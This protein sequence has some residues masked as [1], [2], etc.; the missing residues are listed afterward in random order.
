VSNLI[1]EKKT[2]QLS[3]VMQ[4][5]KRDGMQTFEDSIL[6]LVR[7]GTVLAEEAAGYGIDPE[8]IERAARDARGATAVVAP[9]AATENE[10][11]PGTEG[12]FDGLHAILGA[13]SEPRPGS[14]AARVS[15]R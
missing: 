8:A 11:S 3:S 4:T 14:L 10:S 7:A 13:S 12:I 15:P 9:A 6:A 2:F 1:R 5:S